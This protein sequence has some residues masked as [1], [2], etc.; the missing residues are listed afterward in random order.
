VLFGPSPSWIG[1]AIS[2][3]RFIGQVVVVIVLFTLVLSALGG[4]VGT[5]ELLIW[6]GLLAVTLTLMFRARSRTKRG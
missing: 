5:L 2:S 1:S 4:G 3:V 6:F